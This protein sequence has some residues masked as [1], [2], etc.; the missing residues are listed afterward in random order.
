MKKIIYLPVL[1][2]LVVSACTTSPT[3]S[4]IEE[5]KTGILF[6]VSTNQDVQTVLSRGSEPVYWIDLTGTETRSFALES[7]LVEV[8]PGPYNVTATSPVGTDGVNTMPAWNTPV[9]RGS[10]DVTVPSKGTVKATITA[11]QINSGVRI[12]FDP[13]IKEAYQALEAK[14]EDSSNESLEYDYDTP[15]TDMGYFDPGILTI[16][17]SDGGTPVNIVGGTSYE[18]TVKIKTNYTITLKTSD[19]FDEGITFDITKEDA[20]EESSEIGIGDG[21]GDGTL[22][23]PYSVSSA[24][25]TMPL[26]GVWVEGYIVGATTLTRSAEALILGHKKT[27]T[28]EKSLVFDI[29]TNQALAQLENLIG[30]NK[31]VKI[32]ADVIGKSPDFGSNGLAVITNIIDFDYEGRES[33]L[34]GSNPITTSGKTLK[35]LARNDI[36][37]MGATVKTDWMSKTGLSGADATT[38]SQYKNLIGRDFNSITLEYEMKMAAQIGYYADQAANATRISWIDNLMA[39][40]AANN[41]AV[42]GHVLIW[43]QD[44]KNLTDE[45]FTKSDDEVKQGML[46]HIETVI[47]RYPGVR[48]WDVVNEAF[49]NVAKDNDWEDY[50]QWD[51]KDKEQ[52]WFKAYGSGRAYVQAAFEKARE[53]VDAEN[54]NCKLFYNDYGTEFYKGKREFM[55]NEIKAINQEYAESHGGKTLID[56]IGLQ[57]HLKIGAYEVATKESIVAALQAAMEAAYYIHISELTVQINNPITDEL[58]AQQRQ[59][60]NDTFDAIFE[61]VPAERLWGITCWGV[62]DKTSNNGE[63]SYGARQALLFDK[64]FNAKP[65]YF[66]I[67]RELAK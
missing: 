43:G 53:V 60:Y 34:D 15:S 56:G 36:F 64:D 21:S 19:E 9:Y 66:D 29:T 10:T 23:S 27:S 39:W 45:W 37:R 33:G 50:W 55:T 40:A 14:I 32:L 3:S 28:V 44:T 2:L 22:A 51:E 13:S 12:V 63:S 26:Q 47:K 61:T 54:L 18:L 46:S 16:T 20:G 25:N 7:E 35:D 58:L 49:A 41:T 8:D 11:T 62:S 6:N 67:I 30:E 17:L 52:L 1:F 24:I 59:L 5:D 65:S 57:M 4:S 42:H 31:K 38:Q 48:S